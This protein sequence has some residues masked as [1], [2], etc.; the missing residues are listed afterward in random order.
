M[1]FYLFENFKTEVLKKALKGFYS[2]IL[3]LFS[4]RFL[5]RFI[6]NNNKFG[7]IL[8]KCDKFHT[9][10]KTESNLSLYDA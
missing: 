1:T 2:G 3:I 5:F 9:L 4:D 8:F 7:K 6:Y 10:N